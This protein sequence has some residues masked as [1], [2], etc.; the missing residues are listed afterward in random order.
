MIAMSGFDISPLIA[1]F[2][3]ISSARIFALAG[4]L[5]ETYR[6]FNLARYEIL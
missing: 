4:Y 5:N 1:K 2:L 6:T 3:T